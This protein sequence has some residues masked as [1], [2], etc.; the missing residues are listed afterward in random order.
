MMKSFL[1]ST[2]LVAAFAWN[3]RADR[4]EESRL[5]QKPLPRSPLIEKLK[6]DLPAE[7]ELEVRVGPR[8]TETAGAFRLGSTALGAAFPGVGKDTVDTRR[9]LGMDEANVGM[10]FDLDWQFAKAW[11]LLFGYKYDQ[12]EKTQTLPTDLSFDNAYFAKGSSFKTE[13][14]LHQMDLTVGRD[15]HWDKT[16]KFMP[17]LG[18]K[19]LVAESEGTG[20]QTTVANPA[21]LGNAAGYATA[22]Y[23]RSDRSWLVT[24][25]AGFDARVYVSRSWYWGITPAFS[26]LSDWWAL[27]GQIYTGYD[28]SQEWGLRAGLDSLYGHYASEESNQMADGGLGAVFIEAVWGF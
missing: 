2:I 19:A 14:D 1:F 17:F 12:A 27:Q 9:D 3:A 11:H 6:G 28:F 13:V 18:V 5:C 26:A 21:N 24:W 16:L 22:P 8:V 10:Q 7:R 20:T 15:L 25:L 4:S 23:H